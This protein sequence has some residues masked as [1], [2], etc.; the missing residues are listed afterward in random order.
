MRTDNSNDQRV[1][2]RTERTQNLFALQ[3]KH[4][5]DT[6]KPL[7]YT[8]THANR[9]AGTNAGARARIAEKFVDIVTRTRARDI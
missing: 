8:D 2:G 5:T 9:L 1:A 3:I 4:Y 6:A 7:S